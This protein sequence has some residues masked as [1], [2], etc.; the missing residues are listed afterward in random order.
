M[1]NDCLTS[2]AGYQSPYIWYIGIAPDVW[3]ALSARYI[4]KH[5]DQLRM[6]KPYVLCVNSSVTL[7]YCNGF[8][9]EWKRLGGTTC[10][11]R[12]CGGGYDSEQIGTTRAQYESTALA[13]KQSGADSI[14]AELEP[15]NQLSFLE[16]LQDQGMD[17]K[18]WPHFAPL[19]MD[20]E[21]IRTAGS[22]ANGIIVDTQSEYLPSEDVP[23]IRQIRQEVGPGLDRAAEAHAARRDPGGSPLIRQHAVEQ[24]RVIPQFGRSPLLVHREHLPSPVLNSCSRRSP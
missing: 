7:T 9:N 8:V 6:H 3:Q 20:P 4:Y 1:V 22:F 2:P 23:A 14:V 12:T 10:S 19:G 15:T 13:I 17:P 5:Q 16:A 18:S 21:T 11:N 24:H